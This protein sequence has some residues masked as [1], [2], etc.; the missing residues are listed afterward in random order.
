MFKHRDI[1]ELAKQFGLIQ[2]TSKYY[3]SA[4]NIKIEAEGHE[5]K[6]YIKKGV[7]YP[8]PQKVTDDHFIVPDEITKDTLSKYLKAE[9]GDIVQSKELGINLK[10]GLMGDKV[11]FESKETTDPLISLLIKVFYEWLC[12]IGYGSFFNSD[13]LFLGLR[14]YLGTGVL[15]NDI[16]VFR[17]NEYREVKPFHCV[18]IEFDTNS[19][20]CLISLFSNVTYQIIAPPIDLGFI[21]SHIKTYNVESF[22]GVH[23]E[24][25]FDTGNKGIWIIDEQ[26]SRKR[27]QVSVN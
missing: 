11:N 6:G 10:K 4:F 24:D 14:K 12:I 22:C 8:T 16:S 23:I 15:E 25:N 26:G 1:I 18:I 9:T 21:E 20:T 17:L 13:R 3:G 7:V 27:V 5:L 19:T 2:E